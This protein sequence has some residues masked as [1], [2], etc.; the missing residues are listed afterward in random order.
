MLQALIRDPHR[1]HRQ[2]IVPL[3]VLKFDRSGQIPQAPFQL[4]SKVV[5]IPHDIIAIIAHPDALVIST[6]F[7]RPLEEYLTN[8]IYMIAG[9]IHADT[10]KFEAAG[11]VLL[12]GR[13]NV[14]IAVIGWL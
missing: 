2:L 7:R 9:T 14:C 5:H 8:P 12:V 1:H 13:T 6:A 4:P 3:D 10:H 11:D